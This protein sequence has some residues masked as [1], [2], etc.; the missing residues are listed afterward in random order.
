MKILRINILLISL[1]ICKQNLHAQFVFGGQT[2]FTIG[3]SASFFAGGDTSFDG[4]LN[5]Q[6]TIVSYS[7]LD[8]GNNEEAGSLKFV[9]VA[10]QFI[11]GGSINVGDMEV[12]KDGGD[13]ILETEQ[14]V[15]TGNLNV[16]MGVIQSEEDDD[17]LVQGSADGGQ[18]GELGYVEGKLVGETTGLPLTFPMGIDNNPNY[19]TLFT[20]QSNVR[21]K[22][23]CRQADPTSLIPT[24]DMVGI[25]DEVEWIV[26]TLGGDSLEVNVQAFF[27]GVDLDNL[28][29]GNNIRAQGY[30]PTIVKFGKNDTTYIDLG[31]A[32]LENTDDRTFGTITTQQ[33]FYIH[34]DEPTRIGIA[35]IPVLITPEF[36]VPNAFAPNGIQEENRIFRPYF[37]GGDVTSINMTVWDSRQNKLY[38]YAENGTSIDLSLMGWDG[39]ISNGQI[40]DGGAYYYSVTMIAGGQEYKKIGSFLLS[41]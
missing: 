7:D 11:F 26:N 21:I 23:E 32:T 14:V 30:A 9:G 36:F 37:A 34:P 35:L 13:V 1:L 10:D 15:V 17:L 29:N 22:V 27:S 5:N 3:S 41:F 18:P 38:E 6:G 2:T 20:D 4:E 12:L 39:T 8:F 24:D 19:L 25:A 33:S 28:S 31:V 40:A 16:Q